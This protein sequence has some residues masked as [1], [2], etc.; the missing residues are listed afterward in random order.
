MGFLFSA[1][2]FRADTVIPRR[3]TVLMTK[4]A[5]FEQHL[6]NACEEVAAVIAGLNSADPGVETVAKLVASRRQLQRQT[7]GLLVSLGTKAKTHEDTGVG[8]PA[9]VVMKDKNS[10][11]DATVQRDRARVRAANRF[12][13]V[14]EA[15]AEGE[16]IPENLDV[17]ARITSRMTQAEIDVLAERDTKLASAA[18]RLGVDSFRKRVQ[19]YR[20]KIRMDY[21]QTAEEQARAETYPS[22]SVSRDN[23]TFRIGGVFDPL[24]WT[25]V[26]SALQLEYRR[27]CDEL[28]S[29]HG[30]SPDNVS[31]QAL[32]D[33]IIRGAAAEPTED[34]NQ[35]GV[36]LHVITDGQTLATGPHEHSIIETVDG[37]P[38]SP[39]TLGQLACDCVIERIDS[40]PDGDV[41]G[42]RKSRTATPSQR[43]ALRALYGCCPISGASWSQIEV[44]QVQFVSDGG[45]TELS[46]LIPISRRWHHLIHDQGWTL[47]MAADRTLTLSRPYGTLQRT[48]AP[49]VPI[50]YQRET[51]YPIAA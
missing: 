9:E 10:V 42:S 33:L 39:G 49:P 29:G 13:L 50:L 4:S 35:P 19:R 38:L 46:N 51:E 30:M 11:S 44:H 23:Q 34:N 40:L 20:D 48:I 3:H 2:L 25:A 12:P 18:S 1:G 22:V 37:I 15:V 14:G 36:V 5:D 16:V 26:R 17:L 45:E 41:K 32:H 28:G 24:Q 6:E 31:A 27:L 7:V 47:E 43:S 21:G 8:P